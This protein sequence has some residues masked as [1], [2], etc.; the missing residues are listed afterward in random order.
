MVGSVKKWKEIGGRKRKEGIEGW[1]NGRRNGERKEE[2]GK[3]ERETGKGAR[4][5]ID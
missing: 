1:T 3:K 5:Y 2:R 4:K